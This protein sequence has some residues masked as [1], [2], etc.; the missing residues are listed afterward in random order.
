MR[1]NLQARLWVDSLR[2]GE[3][4]L[5]KNVFFQA[6][7]VPDLIMDHHPLQPCT[8]VDHQVRDPSLLHILDLG[9]DM[10]LHGHKGEEDF[11][12]L[13]PVL[14]HS[15]Q[16]VIQEVDIPL[17]EEEDLLDQYL[18]LRREAHRPLRVTFSQSTCLRLIPSHHW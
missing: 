6:L 13:D 17:H 7:E 5:I 1:A 18:V 16:E 11:N 14:H 10:G 9:Q 4:K 3:Q 15:V 8:E 2:Y 12:H